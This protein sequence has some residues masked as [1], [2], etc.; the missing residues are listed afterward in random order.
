MFIRNSNF[1]L[2][3]GLLAIIAEL[4]Y[5][6]H[7]NHPDKPNQWDLRQFKEVIYVE[8]DRFND[9]PKTQ[10]R[11]E[12]YLNNTD[13]HNLKDSR[14]LRDFIA[15]IHYRTTSGQLGWLNVNEKYGGRNGRLGIQMFEQAISDIKQVGTKAI[16][17]STYEGD[18]FWKAQS[19]A[20]WRDPVHPSV[21]GSGYYMP[22]V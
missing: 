19:Q 1:Y 22:I 17:E 9:A 3:V 4:T 14:G 21:G 8:D 20:Q 2:F 16:W 18:P 11:K 5:I 15:D 12:Y 7:F 13:I 10:I 6:I